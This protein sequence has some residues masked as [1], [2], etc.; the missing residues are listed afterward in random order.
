MLL[1]FVATY[2]HYPYDGQGNYSYSNALSD[3]SPTGSTCSSNKSSENS[4]DAYLRELLEKISEKEKCILDVDKHLVNSMTK[5]LYVSED[6]NGYSPC[7]YETPDQDP[8]N[9]DPTNYTTNRSDMIKKSTYLAR[10]YKP[11]GTPIKSLWDSDSSAKEQRSYKYD[12]KP[13]ERRKNPRS[14]VPDDKKSK[15]YWDKR[16]KNNVAA[17]KSREDRRKKEIEILKTVENLKNDNLKLK[18]YA[19]KV[20]SENQNLKYEIDMLKRL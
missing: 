9:N 14:F 17:R 7:A 2:Q 11:D 4:S 20:S 12:P 5:S 1:F 10:F 15:E 18:I 8:N 19:Q 16:K 3:A 13:L 6:S